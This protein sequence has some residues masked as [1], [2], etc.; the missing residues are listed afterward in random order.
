MKVAFINGI[1]LDGTL[2]MQPRYDRAIVVEDGVIKDIV[3][4]NALPRGIETID[5]Q[6]QYIMPGLI[7]LHVHLPGSGKPQKEPMDLKKVVGLVTKNQLTLAAAEALCAGYAKT[8]LMS[9]V[10]TIRTVGGLAD[11]DAKIRDKVARG[12]L[13][14]PR[15]LASNMALSVSGGHMA[16]SL[17]YEAHSEEEAV[18]LVDKIA[19]TGPDLIKLMVTGG[20]MDAEV[21]GEPGVLRMAPELVRAATK[22]A[23]KLGL[24][25]A[26]HVESSEGVRVALENGVDSIEH[27][28]EPDEDIIRLFKETGACHVATISPALPYAF[29]DRSVSHA[30]AEQQMNGKV[31]L[32]GIV[33]CAKAC[34]EAGVPVGLGTDV[35]C[36][37]VTHYDMWRELVY[38]VKYCGVTPSFALHTATLVNARLAGIDNLTGSIEKGKMADMIVT[39]DNPLVRP[40]ALRNVTMVVKE[41]QIIESPK[42]KKIAIC[43]EELDKFM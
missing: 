16:G 15:I 26:A 29:F 22:R 17:A 21:V 11:V 43:E 27:G 14:G 19:E 20:V 38:F 31:V 28:A 39:R 8:A 41:G 30:T 35:G 37:F 25:V 23:H 7:N 40:H 10:T 24:M 12:K 18:H 3:L 13:V 4:E 42:V 34:L 6:G 36:P 1:I 9:G 33:G 2:D 32:D 5:L